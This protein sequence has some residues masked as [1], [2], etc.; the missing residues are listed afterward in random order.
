MDAL[1]DGSFQSFDSLEVTPLDVL[2]S[3]KTFLLIVPEPPVPCSLFFELLDACYEVSKEKQVVDVRNLLMRVSSACRGIARSVIDL[4][5]KVLASQ[6][7]LQMTDVAQFLGSALVRPSEGLPAET[8]PQCY[9]ITLSLLELG[10]AAFDAKAVPERP[11]P[12][13][14]TLPSVPS[15]QH[16][17]EM[18][19][20]NEELKTANEK[21]ASLTRQLDEARKGQVVLKKKLDV[22]VKENGELKRKLAD[23]QKIIDSWKANAVMDMY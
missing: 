12:A 9:A 7:G 4:C 17:A 22:M 10:D 16:V 8:D 21:V 2:Q 23:S 20:L 13:T 14:V 6:P 1:A 11:T 5:R 3:V 15:Q 19:A 18:E